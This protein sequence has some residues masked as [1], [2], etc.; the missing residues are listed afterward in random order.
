MTRAE[1][2]RC[3]ISKYAPVKAVVSLDDE[4]KII[5]SYPSIAD[6]AAK[7]NL[8]PS[9]ICNAIKRKGRAGGIR[10]DYLIN[11]ESK[12]FIMPKRKVITTF[13]Q[14]HLP[15]GG[16]YGRRMNENEIKRD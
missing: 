9:S 7:N 14:T 1:K 3:G 5:E 13:Q 12:V 16:V 8:K 6:A 2:E 4:G 11:E 15:Y 10:F